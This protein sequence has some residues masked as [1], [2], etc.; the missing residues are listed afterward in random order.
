VCSAD[1]Y[2]LEESSSIISEILRGIYPLR[3]IRFTCS[4]QIERDAMV[5]PFRGTLAESQ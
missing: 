4:G 1:S 5:P 2:G 3:F